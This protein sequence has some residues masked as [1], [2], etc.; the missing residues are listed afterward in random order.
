MSSDSL[1]WRANTTAVAEEARRRSHLLGLPRKKCLDGKLLVAFHRPAAESVPVH[2][3]AE[4]HTGCSVAGRQAINTAQNILVALCLTCC[5]LAAAA[6]HFVSR[7]S[8]CSRPRHTFL[9]ITLCKNT[10]NGWTPGG[11]APVNRP[12]MNVGRH[13]VIS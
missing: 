2:R 8:C 11:D 3:A 6:G 7:I 1:T 4:R 5:P 13:L 9:T 12:L 10:V